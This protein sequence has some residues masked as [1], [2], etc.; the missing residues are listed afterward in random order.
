MTREPIEAISAAKR[1]RQEDPISSELAAAQVGNVLSKVSARVNE[2]WAE[3]IHE[4]AAL[5][6]AN[7]VA[8]WNARHAETLDVKPQDLQR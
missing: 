6:H 7:D 3:Q 8:R 5:N 1:S 2:R 4:N